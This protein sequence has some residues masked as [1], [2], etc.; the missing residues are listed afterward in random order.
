[1]RLFSHGHELVDR[2]SRGKGLSAAQHST[3]YRAKFI[4]I[5]ESL[6]RISPEGSVCS[7]KR[8]V[9]AVTISFCLRRGPPPRKKAADARERE[10]DGQRC[11]WHMGGAAPWDMRAAGERSECLLENCSRNEPHGRHVAQRS[12]CVPAEVGTMQQP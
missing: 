5:T 7:R 1:M 10:R 2:R 9:G 3:P 12:S 6:R 4:G 11:V 8:S